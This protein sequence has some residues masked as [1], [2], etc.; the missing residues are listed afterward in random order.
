MGELLDPCVVGQRRLRRTSIPSGLKRPNGVVD[1][2]EDVRWSGV[3]LIHI[4][5]KGP[6]GGGSTG[7]ESGT[8]QINGWGIGGWLVAFV[9]ESC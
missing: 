4:R 7:G 6:T 9:A 8:G 1:E 5:K 2:L 3:V